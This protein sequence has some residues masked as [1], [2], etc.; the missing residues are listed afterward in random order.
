MSERDRF[1]FVSIICMGV[2]LN[3]VPIIYLIA[4]FFVTKL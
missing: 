1:E 2:A 4:Y 3:F